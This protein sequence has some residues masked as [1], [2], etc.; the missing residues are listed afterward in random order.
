LF[1][2]TLKDFLVFGEYL[3]PPVIPSEMLSFSAP[4][5]E[6]PAQAPALGIAALRNDYGD[7]VLILSNRAAKELRI[8][9]PVNYHKL[10]LDTTR[11]TIVVLYDEKGDV[12]SII[13]PQ[14]GVSTI[15]VNIQPY[16]N[17]GILFT[18]NPYLITTTITYTETITATMTTT[19]ETV[20]TSLVETTTIMQTSTITQT[21]TL[22]AT[23]VIDQQDTT[24][25]YVAVIA[26]LLAGIT[27]GILIRKALPKK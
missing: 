26:S 12:S 16:K 7:S 25:L 23:S 27:V 2:R 22:T 18:Q 20:T 19:T 15:W 11:K 14:D 17:I 4:Y 8:A 6:K 3:I 13:Q 9:I 21:T 24:K 5:L 10:N 1:R